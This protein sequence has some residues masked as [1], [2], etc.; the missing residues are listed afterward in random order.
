MKT[1][2]L[3]SNMYVLIK[4]LEEDHSLSVM[5]TYSEMTTRSKCIVVVVKNQTTVPIT[6]AKG[7]KFTQALAANVAPKVEV[8]LGTLE[9]LDEMQGVQ[10]VKMSTGQGKEAL[11]QQLDCPGWRGGLLRIELLHALC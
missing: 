6:I 1:M 3:G 7:I 11:F 9:K 2:F 5:N 10:R 8:V 4:T